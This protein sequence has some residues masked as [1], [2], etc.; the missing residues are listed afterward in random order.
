MNRAPE[1]LHVGRRGHSAVPG[2]PGTPRRSRQP[3][4]GSLSPLFPCESIVRSRGAPWLVGTVRGWLLVG[5]RGSVQRKSPRVGCDDGRAAAESADSSDD[6]I[7]QSTNFY[8]EGARSF[9]PSRIPPQFLGLSWFTLY[10][11]W[12]V[13]VWRFFMQSHRVHLARARQRRSSRLVLLSSSPRFLVFICVLFRV[14]FLR[15]MPLDRFLLLS[16]MHTF[17]LSAFIY[18][19]GD[20][21]NIF[22]LLP[23]SPPPQPLFLLRRSFFRISVSLINLALR[24]APISDMNNVLP[25]CGSTSLLNVYLSIEQR[26][27]FTGNRALL[28]A[29]DSLL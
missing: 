4:P 9:L 5:A 14:S 8:A 17:H 25:F 20:N 2:P 16:F 28:R 6:G 22:S 21:R 11:A 18:R 12:A 29:A 26:F 23:L 13:F 7:R 15:P 27:V 10:F 24:L 3:P 19:P 1:H